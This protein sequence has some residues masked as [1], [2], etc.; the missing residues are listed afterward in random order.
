MGILSD[1][2]LHRYNFNQF[3][4]V[5]PGQAEQ[6]DIVNIPLK[7]TVYT[8]CFSGLQTFATAKEWISG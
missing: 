2:H 1:D 8:S 7:E 4:N 5:P 6:I 3:W